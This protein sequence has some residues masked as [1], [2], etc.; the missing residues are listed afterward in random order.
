MDTNLRMVRAMS[1][2]FTKA[3]CRGIIIITG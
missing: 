2:A 1:T 3:A